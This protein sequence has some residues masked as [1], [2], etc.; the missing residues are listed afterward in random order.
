MASPTSTTNQG[1]SLQ[2]PPEQLQPP[3]ETRKRE[4]LEKGRKRRQRRTQETMTKK[5]EFI[6]WKSH[7][8]L[9]VWHKPRNMVMKEKNFSTSYCSENTCGGR[10]V[11][12][13]A[14]P[15]GL[16]E[17]RTGKSLWFIEEACGLTGNKERDFRTHHRL[18]AK[19]I[20]LITSILMNL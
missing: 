18:K 19:L 16:W 7:Q 5:K 4:R 13:S 9:H 14:K 11:M 10:N 2:P 20:F 8:V 6:V 3:A 17:L 1:S 12:Q 15:R